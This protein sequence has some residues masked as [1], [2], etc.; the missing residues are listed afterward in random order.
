M[1]VVLN[2]VEKLPKIFGERGGRHLKIDRKFIFT[3]H[4]PRGFHIASGYQCTTQSGK[5]LLSDW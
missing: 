4:R 3:I 1:A 5:A 2:G